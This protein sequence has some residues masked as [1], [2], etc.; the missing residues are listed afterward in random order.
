MS[1]IGMENLTA[2]VAFVRT[3]DAHSFTIAARRLGISPSGVSKAISR[4]EASF[5]VR[6]LHRTSR[7]VTLTPEGSAFYQRCRRSCP[8]WKTRNSC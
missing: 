5:R 2:I 8:T 6:L 4:L 7:S 1:A 3:A